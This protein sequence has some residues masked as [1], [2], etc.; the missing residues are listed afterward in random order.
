MAKPIHTHN[1]FIFKLN[2]CKETSIRIDYCVF[3]TMLDE[4]LLSPYFP[5]N[6]FIVNYCQA[7]KEP[8]ILQIIITSYR[9]RIS[10]IFLSTHMHSSL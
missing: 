2:S 7:S 9:K 10:I 6:H 1:G 8:Q 4:I 5:Y 3:V